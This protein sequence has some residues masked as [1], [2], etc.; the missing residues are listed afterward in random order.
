MKELLKKTAWLWPL[1]AAAA[2]LALQ[3]PWTETLTYQRYDEGYTGCL[4][5][6]R[7]LG[8]RLHDDLWIDQPPLFFTLLFAWFHWFGASL[9]K[10][11]ALVF[12]L[13]VLFSGLFFDTI[14]RRSTPAA[15]W[16][17]LVFLLTRPV[18]AMMSVTMIQELPAYTFAGLALWLATVRTGHKRPGLLLALSAVAM[19]CALLVKLSAAPFVPLIA[20]DLF[21]R[22]RQPAARPSSRLLSIAAWGLIAGVSFAA[23]GW[24]MGADFRE[25]VQ[26]HLNPMETP[27]L[28]L[29]SGTRMLPVFVFANWIP[30]LLAAP[31]FVYGLRLR[32]YSF[33]PPL[34]W[35]F[36]NAVLLNFYK[37]VADHYEIHVIVPLCWLAGATLARAASGR[38]LALA[39]TVALAA[40]PGN[41]FILRAPN[42]QV[43]PGTLAAVREYA[44]RTRWMAA[45]ECQIYPFAA[46]V[47]VIPD[48]YS[49]SLKRMLSGRMSSENTLQQIK[50]YR[51]EQVMMDN[52]F[53]YSPEL[54]A[55]LAAHYRCRLPDNAYAQ[56]VRSD[57]ADPAGGWLAD[58]FRDMALGRNEARLKPFSLALHFLKLNQP[59]NARLILEQALELRT[60]ALAPHRRDAW[61]LLGDILQREG[62]EDEARECFQKAR[63]PLS[64]GGA[65]AP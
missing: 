4:M 16:L 25:L 6:S 34:L 20:F 45:I 13:S 40:I 43:Y 28:S 26:A 10:G 27:I 15:A 5:T 53:G 39:G 47:N 24:L 58:P 37:P 32:E 9:L 42:W 46:G 52:A 48:L 30:M 1:L 17:A 50:Q 22:P 18:Y 36:L 59:P 35:L 2:L 3:V 31:S 54:A 23:I 55:Y 60:P 19:G 44:P 33:G 51:P 56:W 62:R 7:A 14:R 21:C 61:G 49:T 8:F 64:S 57:V 11:R 63:A 65:P 41:R 38:W 12:L 29:R